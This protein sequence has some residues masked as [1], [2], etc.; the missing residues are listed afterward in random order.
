VGRP[1]GALALRLADPVTFI[2]TLLCVGRFRAGAGCAHARRLVVTGFAHHPY[3]Q[4][5]H[6]PPRGG[7]VSPG[8][9]SVGNVRTLERLLDRSRLVRR[10]LP[11]WYTEFGYQTNPPDRLFGVTL[12]DQAIY[13]NQADYLAARDKRVKSVAQYKLVDEQDQAS[14]QTGLERY[15][16][17]AH[18]PA[19]A[20][21]MLPI[22]AVRRGG[23]VAVYGQ[24]RPAA[25]SSV[26]TVV[27]QNAAKAA[28]PW[29]T[30]KT[31]T[32]RS[33]TGQFTTT[34]AA[35][36]GVWRLRWTPAGGGARRTSRVAQA[37]KR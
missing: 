16:T 15:G 31:I 14:F 11:I 5:A 17:L 6:E 25:A 8:Q 13:L 4:G 34:T 10:G 7:R 2:S 18:K 21:Y 28:G 1:D 30:V 37:G 19:F 22:W 3:T 35:K 26:E 12:A 27:L 20:A 33:V 32:V 24:V 23:S 9:L 29:T 36:P